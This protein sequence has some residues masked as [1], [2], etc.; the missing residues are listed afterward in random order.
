[1]A[2]SHL[3]PAF[4]AYMNP[5]LE[6]LRESGSGLQIPDL[7]AKVIDR[8]RI[9]EA[10]LRIRHGDD[11]GV[12][13]VS[14]LMAWARTYL[15]KAGLL[16][17]PR[18]GFW[19]TTE[20]GNSSGE[21]DANALV[22][23]VSR[24]AR[25]A[26]AGA[27]AIELPG[28][29][30]EVTATP[31]DDAL[32]DEIISGQILTLHGELA[33][34]GALL[35]QPELEVVLGRFRQR[36]GPDV[37]AGVDGERL[38]LAMHG[39]ERKDSLA[40]WLEFKDDD[41]HPA[42]FG[43]I[44]GGSA[45]KFG[46][47][48]AAESNQWMTGNPTQQRRL[49]ME[50][51]IAIARSQR[52]Q[53]LASVK[54]LADFENSDADHQTLQTRLEAAAPDLSEAAWVHKYLYLLFP[55]VLA[56][57]HSLD[58]Q[59]FQLTKL[60][61]LPADGRYVN[62][63]TFVRGAAQVGLSPLDFATTLVRRN[64]GPHSYWRVG[65]SIDD[66][67]VWPRMRDGGYAAIGW[68]AVGDLTNNNSSSDGRGHLRS[69]IA[70]RY[71][72]SAASATKAERQ[73]NH[74]VHDA[75]ERDLVVAMAGETVLGL[76][77]IVGPYEF[78]DGDGA[79]AHRHPVE[80]LTLGEWK[81]PAKEAI[82]SAFLP[83]RKPENLIAVERRLLSSPGAGPKSAYRSS[84]VEQPFAPSVRAT[85]PPLSGM[86]ARIDGIL[87][88][89]RQAILFGPPGTG[90]TFWADRAAREL[91]SRAWF[92]LESTKLD[93]SQTAELE[94]E[95]AIEMCSF[96]PAYGYEDFIEGYR[97]TTLPNGGLGFEL[98]NGVFKQLCARASRRPTKTFFLIIDEINRGDVPRIFGEL[99]TVIERE[100][101]GRRITLP[102]SAEPFSV[103]DNVF[104]IGTMNTADRSIALLDAALRRRFGFVELLPDSSTL[105]GVAIEGI[106]LGP[107]LDE[108]NRRVVKYLG[109]DSRHLQVG[110]SYLLSG[111]SPIREIGRFVEVLRDD[112]I[113][114]LEEYCYEDIEALGQILGPTLVPRGK[115]RLELS[116]LESGRHAELVQALLSAF[117]GIT[118][119]RAAV[120]A[121][122]SA[123]AGAEDD[124]D[125][126]T[127]EDQGRVE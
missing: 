112:I 99:L 27:D 118:T 69:L 65:T 109:R 113:P 25:A 83:V 92:G 66:E 75:R 43:S 40:Y 11:P 7:D 26:R 52:D 125:D 80:W 97:P 53:L 110:H 29:D 107:W 70:E 32:L 119:T 55:S 126:D 13:E 90:K 28:E 67:D 120:A 77:R 15:K 35:S 89:K 38:L 58:Y 122:A 18:R 123:V 59:R 108:L 104:V 72:S 4:Q 60:L 94:R 98:R 81:L 63:G 86:L 49:T 39:R 115:Q 79:G 114:L 37:L 30:P 22:A 41:E 10:V 42:R 62:D 21:V 48:Q 36:F 57:C 34:D 100:K 23:E 47:Y 46:I 87:H 105:A 68:D 127:H 106:P 116:L 102:I 2:S 8:M 5:I 96:H 82:R 73:L 84:N 17:N 85:P 19:L 78:R 20:R 33:A 45:L 103:P 54:V 31:T 44:S 95:G 6:V 51:A 12:S 16:N 14:Y 61:K 1:M 76:G 93:K 24:T 91:V 88:R 74:F 124:E 101:R 56:P 50:E 71:R 64:G 117:D 9:P 121:D 3:V 111:D